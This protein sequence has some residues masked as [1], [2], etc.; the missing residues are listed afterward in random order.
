MKSTLGFLFKR[1]MKEAEITG[2]I[3]VEREFI[4]KRQLDRVFKTQGLKADWSE[5][6]QQ[7][8]LMWG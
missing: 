8:T 1:E 6:E 7:K 5:Y 2:A 4:T 3:M